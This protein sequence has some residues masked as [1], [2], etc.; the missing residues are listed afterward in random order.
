MDESTNNRKQGQGSKWEAWLRILF[1]FLLGA[2]S[3]AFL[4]GGKSRDL[5]ELLLWKSEVIG[6][7]RRLDKEGTNRS[8]WVDDKQSEQIA[9]N[10]SAIRELERKSEARGETINV[11][12]GKIQRIER[13]LKLE[14]Y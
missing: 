7:L 6:D 13:E 11:M 3:A 14:Q 1:S 5:S 4:A 12:Q 8:H 9:A 10:L 2:L